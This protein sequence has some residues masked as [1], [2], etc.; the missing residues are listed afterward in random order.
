MR[1]MS[2]GHGLASAPERLGDNPWFAI[3]LPLG[4]AVLGLAGTIIVLVVQTM[5]RSREIREA[6]EENAARELRDREDRLRVERADAYED[7]IGE[8]AAFMSAFNAHMKALKA[9]GALRAGDRFVY[10]DGSGMI[11][12]LA[13]LTTRMQS[14]ELFE[15]SSNCLQWGKQLPAQQYPTVIGTLQERLDLWYVNR[16][17]LAETLEAMEFDRQHYE[18]GEMVPTHGPVTPGAREIFDVR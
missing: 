6:R 15:A 9:A 4:I 7:I 2:I 16:R 14:P 17:T 11:R 13:R 18:K 10:P 8:F 5:S 3:G 12:A 1:G